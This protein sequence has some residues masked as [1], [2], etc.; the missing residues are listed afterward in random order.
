MTDQI[1]DLPEP[2]KKPLK[3]NQRAFLAA[4]AE[5]G[6]IRKAA[7][8]AQTSRTQHWEWLKNPVYA[9]AFLEAGENAADLL[10]AEARRRAIEGTDEPVFFQG[11]QCGQIRKFS[12]TLLIFLLKGRRKE[13][14][15]NLDTLPPSEK[16]DRIININFTENGTPK[17]KENE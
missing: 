12:D 15:N 13:V 11:E 5:I 1:H 6:T 14:F 9:E 7:E 4:F 2:N 8:A 10:E 3:P 17:K 16:D